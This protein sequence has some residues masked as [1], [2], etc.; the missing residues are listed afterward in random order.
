MEGKV[1]ELGSLSRGLRWVECYVVFENCENEVA[2][3]IVVRR[4]TRFRSEASTLVIIY[5]FRAEVESS[6]FSIRTEN[7]AK[8]LQ[9]E[10]VINVHNMYCYSKEGKSYVL[11]DFYW[12]NLY[13]FLTKILR[14][15]CE[16]MYTKN[17][18]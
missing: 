1:Q 2:T 6:Y 14:N 3:K 10:H 8:I 15:K 9:Q 16:K 4:M 5:V 17:N 12:P 13:S 18:K 7:F 11:K